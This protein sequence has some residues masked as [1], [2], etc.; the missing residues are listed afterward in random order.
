MMKYLLL[1]SLILSSV[2][3]WAESGLNFEAEN[4]DFSLRKSV[5][6]PDSL[7]WEV[8]GTYSF[9]NTSEQLVKQII[10][11]PIPCRE[12]LS[13]QQDLKLEKLEGDR[14]AV[15]ELISSSDQGFS[16]GLD[17]PPESYLSI[18]IFYRQSVG[19]KQASYILTT[20]NTWAQPLPSAIYSLYVEKGIRLDS[21]SLP[22][23]LTL[24]SK[25]GDYYFWEYRNFRPKQDFVLSLD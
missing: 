2:L 6:H 25:T 11:F 19:G 21:V 14:D 8:C 18:K 15:C 20:A 13:P 9:S 22:R 24:S 1:V 4:I 5:D 10:A 7:V 17:L 23:P 16:F 12:G 3:L